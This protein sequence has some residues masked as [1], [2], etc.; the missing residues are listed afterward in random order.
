MQQRVNNFFV[1]QLLYCCMFCYCS[2]SEIPG[3]TGH[4]KTSQKRAQLVQ[5]PSVSKTEQNHS[6]IW[7][8][9]PRIWNNQR[10][11]WCA[12]PS[13]WE[14]EEVV[15]NFLLEPALSIWSLTVPWQ[16]SSNKAASGVPACSTTVLYSHT[17]KHHHD[18]CTIREAVA[19][20]TACQIRWHWTPNVRR[21]PSVIPESLPINDLHL[22]NPQWLTEESK[23]LATRRCLHPQRNKKIGDHTSNTL[24][25]SNWL[26]FT[27]SS[28][29]KGH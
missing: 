11:S 22:R 6:W 10:W 25:G 21:F 23:S 27:E 3:Q 28:R 2:P 18:H 5:V 26:S 16:N 20:Q 24:K 14:M 17:C 9:Q 4:C 12:S 7:M 8:I 1:S 19:V 15:L 13:K 29:E